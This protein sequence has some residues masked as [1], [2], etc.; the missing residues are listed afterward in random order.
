MNHGMTENYILQ[1]ARAHYAR[2]RERLSSITAP[3]AALARQAEIRKVCEEILGPRPEQVPL[4]IKRIGSLER[5]GYTV[6]MLTYQSFPGVVTTANLYLPKERQASCPG[7]LCFTSHTTD[8][9]SH[10]ESQRLGQLLARRKMAAL[11]F[12]QVGQGERLEFYDP[13]LQRSWVGKSVAG[14]HAQLGGVMLLTGH[15]LGHWMLWDA[16]R[17]LDVLL[18][19]AKADPKRLG[20]TSF[21]AGDI[22]PRLLCTLDSRVSAAVAV[23]HNP[24]AESL[25]NNDADQD[26]PGFIANGISTLDLFAGFAPKPLLLAYCSANKAEETLQADLAELTHMYS[27]L[28]GRNNVA[29]FKPEGTLDPLKQLRARACE[30]LARSFKLGEQKVREPETPPESAEALACTETGQVG[31]SLN[32]LSM[33]EFHKQ[34]SRDLPPAS[35]VPRTEAEAI[36]LQDDVRARIVPFLHL[37]EPMFAIKSEI[38][39]RSS[40]WGFMAEKGRLVV[41]EGL[42]VPYSFYALPEN[43]DTPGDRRAAPTVLALHERGIASVSSQG[44]WM[45]AFAAS[46][47]HVMSIDVPGIGETRLAARDESAEA[48]DSLLCG[49][50]SLWMRRALNVGL[51][52]FGIRVFSVLRTLSFLRTRWDVDSSRISIVGVG[53]GGLWGLYAAALDREVS[54]VTMLRSLSSYKSLVDHPHHNHH[55]SLYIPGCLREY[56]LPHVAAALAPRR[57]ALVNTVDHCKRRCDAAA[58]EREYALTRAVYKARGK[59]DEFRMVQSD[60]APETLTAV[61][62]AI[63][64]VTNPR[65]A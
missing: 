32:A 33:F 31:N 19:Y 60:S 62:A 46:G 11:V 44:A 21:E 6:E 51:N 3:A 56:D 2:R 58:L 29:A 52:L 65:S 18:E 39:S 48:Y 37:P 17:G 41:D 5:E 34:I 47:T 8:G 54:C 1:T 12:D 4:K 20:I 45:Q 40:D 55:L 50:E 43:I 26:L 53:R 61:L 9:K 13:I 16:M 7:V 35:P 57:L 25:G 59:T 24:D 64:A 63:G 30:H 15:H 49:Q 28:N 22:L 38:E 42:Y 36:A 10:A 23:V 27:T 14:E